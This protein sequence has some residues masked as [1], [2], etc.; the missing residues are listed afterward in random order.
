MSDKIR[1]NE[2]ARII[3]CQKDQLLRLIYS[4]KLTAEQDTNGYY[5]VTKEDAESLH[6]RTR[7][8]REST[9]TLNEAAQFIRVGRQILSKRI[10]AKLLPS[11]TDP[12]TGILR[13]KTTDLESFKESRNATVPA[14]WIT[15][16]K[17]TTQLGCS[18]TKL[19]GLINTKKLTTLDHPNDKRLYYVNE[20]EVSALKE[21]LVDLDNNW[22][23]LYRSPAIVGTTTAGFNQLIRIGAINPTATKKVGARVYYQRTELERLKELIK[24]NNIPSLVAQY[25]E[26]KAN[27]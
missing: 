13:I 21:E 11:I 7:I 8:I 20:S 4:G 16:L 22:V 23:V 10:K 3:G 27:G 5:I 12:I 24:A 25:E 6:A 9:K 19:Q 26:G 14:G 17:A 15:P 2:A 1:L 18:H